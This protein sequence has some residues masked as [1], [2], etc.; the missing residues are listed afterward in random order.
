[1]IQLYFETKTRALPKDETWRWCYGALNRTSRSFALVIQQLPNELKNSVCVFYLVLRALDTIE[2][3]MSVDKSVKVPALRS[4]HEKI[5]DRGFTMQC[6]TKPQ[7]I[8]L[9]SNYARVAD[10]YLTLPQP[11]QRVIKDITRRMGEGMSKFIDKEVR[12]VEDWDEYC[13]YVAG[14]VGIGLSHLFSA[15]ELEAGELAEMEDLAN[16]MGLFLQKTNIIRDYLEDINEEPAPR[17]FWPEE[18]W[19]KYGKNLADFKN[20]QNISSAVHCLDHLVVNALG[21]VE[22][23]FDYMIRLRNPAIFRFCAIPQVMAMGTLS[24]CYNNPEVFRGI[25][26]MRRGQTATLMMGLDGMESLYRSYSEFA[27]SIS[28]K[29]QGVHGPKDEEIMKLTLKRVERIEELCAKGIARYEKSRDPKQTAVD[30]PIPIPVRLGVLFMFGGYFMY[31]W[32]MRDLRDSLGV[33]RP[34][35]YRIDILQKTM[36][37]FG[38]LFALFILFTGKRI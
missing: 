14:L 1:V 21:H 3:D 33:D 24:L 6:G 8:E 32:G 16:N 9:M 4:F 12:T 13:H 2:D 11:M 38:L 23:C 5:S 28:M 29:C 27:R 37:C 26:K 19:G 17:M 31:A 18:I 22:G 7:E 36:A 25:V 35:D 15:S 20:P 10:A 34:G 30:E